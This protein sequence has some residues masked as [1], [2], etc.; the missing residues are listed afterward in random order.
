MSPF[1][2]ADR[3]NEPILLIHGEVDNNPGTYPMQSERLFEALKGLGKTTSR[4]VMLPHES[5]S[6]RARESLLHMLWE[7]EQWLDRYVRN[8]SVAKA[9][10]LN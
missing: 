1:V 7:S 10:P 2:H 5:H 8:G 4:L 9:A 6:Y 3:I